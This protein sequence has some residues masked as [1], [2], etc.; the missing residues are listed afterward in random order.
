[1]DYQAKET[2]LKEILP[3]EKLVWADQPKQGIVF[4]APD[5]YMIPFTLIWLYFVSLWFQ[6]IDI[7]ANK[8]IDFSFLLMGIPHLLIGI[9]LL[10]GRFLYDAHRRKN[11]TYGLT[12]NRAIIVTNIFRTNIKSIQLKDNHNISFTQKGNQL[13]TIRFEKLSFWQSFLSKGD[14]NGIKDSHL[15]KFE[16]IT[17]AESVYNQ[18]LTIQNSL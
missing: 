4:R 13:G 6:G 1:M 5:L 16:L 8:P 10:I 17:N 11:T 9:Y 15:P 7:T 18:I 14:M 12:K 3:G 2:I